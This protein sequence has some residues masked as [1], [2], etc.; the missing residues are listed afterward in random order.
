M[1]TPLLLALMLAACGGGDGSDNPEADLAVRAATHAAHAGRYVAHELEL[2]AVE[3]INALDPSFDLCRFA[4]GGLRQTGG[5]VELR[6]TISYAPFSPSR[7]RLELRSTQVTIESIDYFL[8]GDAGGGVDVA[9][10]RVSYADALFMAEGGAQM[11]LSGAIPMPA[12]R[13]PGC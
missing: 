11:T 4:F 6:G 8:Q 13:P 5:S 12:T 3:R 9:T 7:P 2:G 10:G 1:R